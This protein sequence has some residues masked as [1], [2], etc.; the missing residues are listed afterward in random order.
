M[1]D[2]RGPGI[3]DGTETDDIVEVGTVDGQGDT[4]DSSGNTISTQDGS[5]TIRAG[6]GDDTIFA[7]NGSD[8]VF[9]GAGDDRIIADETGADSDSSEPA[10]DDIIV[11]G[12]GNDTVFGGAGNDAIFGDYKP[13][14]PPV[15]SV[16]ES[17]N[18]DD[19]GAQ[20]DGDAITAP[21]SQDTG[22]VTVTLTT[23]G[24]TSFEADAQLVS[25]LNTGE[26]AANPN[27]GA[28]SATGNGVNA[29]ATQALAFSEAVEN[30][31]FRIN[32]IDE[33][34]VVKVRAWDAD[35]NPVEVT[36]TAS[37]LTNLHLADIDG[38]GATE[39][40]IADGT[41]PGDAEDADN[42]VV[43]DIPGPVARLEIITVNLDDTPADVTISDVFFDATPD[44]NDLL[45][46]GAGDDIILG[47]FGDDTIVG[48]DG[49]DTMFG[50]EDQDTFVLVGPGDVI[51][52]NESGV[53]FDTIN[54]FRA[55]EDANPGGTLRIEFD[56][57]NAENGT[58]F[59]LD[60]NGVET[61]SAI[62]R[63]IENIT[64]T[65]VVVCFTPGTRV[66]TPMG[67]VPVENLQAGDKVVTRDNGLQ[68]IRWTGRKHV[69]GRE[70]MKTPNLRPILIKKGTLG[71]NQPERD[72]M[73]SPNHRMLLVSERAELLF[74]ER[75]VLVAAKH[76][77][78]LEG[79][80][81][82]DTVGVEYIH[83]MCD[84][85]EVVLADGAWS[86]SF[87]PGEYSLD[88]IGR[89]Q[90]DEIYALFPELQK[91]EGLKRYT[92]ARLSLK[93]DEA[94]LLG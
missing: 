77:T 48:M 91:L 15:Q 85:H 55:A 7:G 71:P 12:A 51:D 61:G 89:E 20:A 62:F 36:L 44:A 21:Q 19:L 50:G 70:L 24:T 9:G 54:L 23:S 43:V 65:P 11:G 34:S 79:V 18:W 59:F 42:S 87:Q 29:T 30:V 45:I 31:Q 40:S 76:L 33:D 47:Q 46:G 78:H 82:V 56:P 28:L 74:E 39:A 25:G 35:G 4:A 1:A 83:F 32:D 58:I 69:S 37:D 52:G 88:G 72:M 67:E 6:A 60:A 49:N 2:P 38:D 10:G 14:T 73:V 22:S 92:A 93:R 5:D 94:K 80:E 75:E 53:D 13:G 66:L 17:F 8:L 26:E 57:D 16:R 3:V 41:A 27:S 68:E 86:E 63:N 81:Q 90:R 84:H 64:D